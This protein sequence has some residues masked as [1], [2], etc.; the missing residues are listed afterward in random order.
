M[1]DNIVPDFT[2]EVKQGGIRGFISHLWRGADWGFLWTPNT[3]DYYTDKQGRE[4]EA[5]RTQWMRADAFFVP[6]GW[7]AGKNLYFGVN[8]TDAPGKHWQR[9]RN[10]TVSAVNCF[11]AEFDA[12]DEISE[13][14]WLPFYEA[15]ALDGLTKAQANGQLQRA[16]TAAIGAAYKQAPDVYKRRALMR[17]EALPVPPSAAWDSGGGYQAVWLLAD[18]IRLT[19]DN[20]AT[21]AHY[22]REFVRM[23]GG[24]PAASD[25]CRVLR[26]PGSRNYK[27]K[28]APNYPEVTFL[29]CDLH[30]VYQYDELIAKLPTPATPTK[31]QR[32]AVHVP[33]GAPVDLGK[34]GDVPQLPRH[35]ALT[36]YNERTNL[37]E[38]LLT[39]GYTD[40]SPGRMNRPGGDSGGVQLHDDNSASIY[41]SGDPLYCSHR[42]RPAHALCVYQYDGDAGAMLADLARPVN[43]VLDAARGWIRRANFAGI[44]PLELQ[45]KNGYRTSDTDKAMALGAVAIL[46]GY[47]ALQG[48][49]SLLQ[50][51]EATGRSVQTCANAMRR[52]APL[53]PCVN[54]EGRKPDE[55]RIYR[56]CDGL[57]RLETVCSREDNCTTFPIYATLPMDTHRAHDA[58]VRSMRPM[59]ADELARRIEF[60]RAEG[61][62]PTATGDE[63][64]RVAATLP[65]AGPAALVVADAIAEHGPLRGVDLRSLT[66]K[67]KCAISRAVGR[68]VGLG[69][70][71]VDD[72]GAVALVDG[73]ADHLNEIAPNMPTAG[74]HRRRIIARADAIIA[75]CE[76]IK[77]ACADPPKWVHRRLNRAQNTKI[78]IAQS[79]G[80][81]GIPT[82]AAATAVNKALTW[83]DMRK[84]MQLNEKHANARMDVAA[85]RRAEQW[86]LTDQVRSLKREGAGQREVVRQLQIAGYAPSETWTAVNAVWKASGVTA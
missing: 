2:S 78:R 53:F 15:P 34:F 21:V 35:G 25:L 76:R 12:I 73:W 85:S 84:V 83:W 75:Q 40:H 52:V 62:K 67:S 72:S 86:T 64:R 61:K 82:I 77:E 71:T 38:L 37:R 24:D 33:T 8:P 9:S 18:T 36:D 4:V 3:G 59:S 19:D 48:P 16:Q 13:A 29:W 68:L 41:S 79:E 7:T 43:Q 39:Y 81:D 54:E 20:R 55:A 42:I 56:L 57:R 70:A 14:E 50:L 32:K 28:Y 65:S 80:F 63:R 49:I 45:A 27:P 58:F 22:Q 66:H 23:V 60:R 11:L 30:T 31:S 26:L 10:N 5:K 47:G 46:A 17:L 1:N 69:L 74:T 51:S 44:V 6:E